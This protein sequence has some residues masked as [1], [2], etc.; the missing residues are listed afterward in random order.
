MEEKIIR[1][2]SWEEV[3][4]DS[5]LT[6][7]ATTWLVTK[8]IDRNIVVDDLTSYEDSNN[9]TSYRIPGE[10]P[11]GEIFYVHILRH[12]KDEDGNEVENNDYEGPIKIIRNESSLSDMV[13]PRLWIEDPG[14]TSISVDFSTGL[15]IELATPDSNVK[16]T[17]TTWIVEADNNI[18]YAKINDKDNIYGLTLG[19]DVFDFSSVDIVKVTVQH[20]ADMEDGTRVESRTIVETHKVSYDYFKIAS[21]LV[22]LDPNKENVITIQPTTDRAITPIAANLYDLNSQF[23]SP[24]EIDGLNIIIPADLLEPDSS[25]KINLTY[26]YQ[27]PNTLEIKTN[28]ADIVFTTIPYNEARF[29]YPD[30]VYKNTITELPIVPASDLNIKTSIVQITEQSVTGLI[31]IF[32]NNNRISFIG[33]GVD[34]KLFYNNQDATIIYANN[35]HKFEFLPT[36][37]GV[38][39]F[40]A[41][42]DY[43]GVYIRFHEYDPYNNKVTY[44][45]TITRTYDTSIINSNSFTTLGNKFYML[46]LSNNTLYLEEF[47]GVN[48]FTLIKTFTLPGVENIDGVSMTAIDIDKLLIIPKTGDSIYTYVY[49]FSL[50]TITQ[51]FALPT[52]FRNVDVISFTRANGNAIIFLQNDDTSFAEYDIYNNTIT[53]HVGS[54]YSYNINNVIK[55][56]SVD[57]IKFGYNGDDLVPFRY[58]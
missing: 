31:P 14:V 36:P 20:I 34:G 50:D 8:D 51:S 12:F 37:D 53:E 9:L 33:I 28:Y 5:S 35:V 40:A 10:I 48:G 24:L 46:G 2:P 44:K 21:N 26:T 4:P 19:P 32:D 42:S 49:D 16:I 29:V 3:K 7:Y 6:H 15:K 39:R 13:V 41:I 56:K 30:R 43:N 52:R 22:G 27:D 57:H 55:L 23:V 38:I 47:N 1:I 54:K 58:E 18:V 17:G 11:L 25:Y 45:N